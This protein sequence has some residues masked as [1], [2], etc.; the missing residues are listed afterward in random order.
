[1]K[2]GGE[3]DQFWGTEQRIAATTGTYTAD[4]RDTVDELTMVP[5]RSILETQPFATSSFSL[6]S[7]AKR[8]ITFFLV[9]LS[10]NPSWSEQVTLT[11]QRLSTSTKL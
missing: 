5:V 6:V 9:S 4:R 8:A 7:F 1:M 10:S 3:K 2:G 11:P